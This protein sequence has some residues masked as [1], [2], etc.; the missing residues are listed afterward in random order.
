MNN[1]T[2]EDCIYFYKGFSESDDRCC[3]DE[4]SRERSRAY[5]I[6][7]RYLEIINGPGFSF[8]EYA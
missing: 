3:I 2:C 8:K 4:F 7:E 6:C 5:P 1:N